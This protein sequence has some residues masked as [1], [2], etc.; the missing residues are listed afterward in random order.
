MTVPSSVTIGNSASVTVIID[1]TA[2]LQGASTGAMLTYEAYTSVENTSQSDDFS[3]PVEL[4]SFTADSKN[5]NISLQWI[6]ESEL[7]NAFW[8]LERKALTPAEYKS[9]KEGRVNVFDTGTPFQL[10]AQIEGQ[11]SIASE[12]KYAF[13]DSTVHFGSVYAYRLADVSYS[14]LVTYH[15]V[16]YQ[17][18]TAPSDFALFNNYPNPFNPSTTFKYNLPANSTIDF[19]V[20]NVLGQEVFTL[21]DGNQEAGFH[22]IQWHGTNRHGV[23]VASGMYIVAFRAKSA[24]NEYSR[25]MK[26]VLIR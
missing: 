8:K 25:M 2:G 11:G 13:L 10:I 12:T 1:S 7:E 20:Y 14:G 24:G 16:I 9:V 17:E 22:Q 15:E 5:G 18:V 26:I 4:T 21:I 23:P 6:T 19:K 3:L